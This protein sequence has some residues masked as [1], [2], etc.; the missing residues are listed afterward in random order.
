MSKPCVSKLNH[1]QVDNLILILYNWKYRK[2][3]NKHKYPNKSIPCFPDIVQVHFHIFCHISANY[4]PIF[5]PW[6][7]T[8]KVEMLSTTITHCVY[9][10]MFPSFPSMC[11][12]PSTVLNTH[13]SL[14]FGMRGIRL[15]VNYKHFGQLNKPHWQ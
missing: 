3:S 10:Y 13:R 12:S 9:P 4:Y 1:S 6:K 14:L 11:H 7:N 15:H 5:I 8:Q 2:F